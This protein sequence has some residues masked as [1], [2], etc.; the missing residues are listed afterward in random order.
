MLQFY[1]VSL[2]V[3]G[4]HRPI[5]NYFKTGIGFNSWLVYDFYSVL[6]PP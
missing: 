2:E 1:V 3:S 6:M 4:Y 5:K